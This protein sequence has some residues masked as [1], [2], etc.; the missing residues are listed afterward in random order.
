MADALDAVVVVLDVVRVA[1][2]ALADA[3]QHVLDVQVVAD[4]P[5]LV[6]NIGVLCDPNIFC[7]KNSLVRP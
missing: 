6:D 5:E 7:P 4:V 2:D 1:Q 3:N